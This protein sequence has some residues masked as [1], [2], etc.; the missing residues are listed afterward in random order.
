MRA[1]TLGVLCVG[2]VTGCA[3]Y[4]L[5]PISPG[6]ASSAHCEGREGKEGYIFHAPQP[7]L[8]GTLKPGT[9][10]SEA[11]GS[12]SAAYDFQI[13]YLPD[14]ERPYRFTRYEFLA[15]SDVSTTFQNGWMLTGAESKTDTTAAVSSL[16]DF[17]K[18]VADI[19]PLSGDGD[20]STLPGVVLYRIDT[21]RT[22]PLELV[23]PR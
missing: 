9:T 22:P 4:K 13:V 10:P 19:V 16:V 6:E 18:A 7:F 23:F 21:S 17:V 20:A 8:M 2:C 11:D 14:Y 15:K 5:T 1:L 12:V 3:G